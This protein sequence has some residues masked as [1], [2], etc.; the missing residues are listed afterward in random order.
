MTAE[1][2]LSLLVDGERTASRSGVRV[3][4]R[5]AVVRRLLALDEA[6]KLESVHV[7]VAAGSAGVSR[8]TVWRWLAIARESG[9]VAPVPRRAAFTFTD[10]LWDRL[11][12]VGGNVAAL[13]RWMMDHV[14]EVLPLLGREALPSLAT[15]H[16]AVRREYSRGRILKAARPRYARVD[17]AAYDRALAELELP[18]TVDEA[19]RASAGPAPGKVAGTADASALSFTGG[20]RLYVPGAHVVSTR[21]LGEVAEA[22]AHTVAARGIVCVYGDPGHGKTVAV[23]HALRVLPRRIPVRRALVAVKPALPQLRAALL[24]AFGLPATALTNR[25][26]AADR[27]LLEAFRA[28]GVLVIDD[29]QRIAAPELDY[30]RLLVDAPSTQASLVLCGAGAERSLARAPALASR[31]LTWQQVPRLDG[32]RVPAVLRLFHPLWDP[33]TDADLLHADTTHAR[34]NFRTWAKVTSHAYAAL[35]RTRGAAVDRALLAGACSRLG[36]TL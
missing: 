28:P 14:E 8:R 32:A 18:G 27:A 31:V 22:L 3:L 26:D 21:Q 25:T 36:P 35:A 34:G 20:V 29:V 13:H 23:H 4:S 15:L 19:G 11:S 7:R 30:L 12:E 17:P 16:L 33:A 1:S 2:S 5:Q 6:G 10:V 9:R 24:T